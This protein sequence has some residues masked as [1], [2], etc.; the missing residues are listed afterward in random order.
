MMDAILA[1][2]GIAA[3]YAFGCFIRRE[4]MVNAPGGRRQFFI[5]V[6]AFVII[7][8]PMAQLLLAVGND[9]WAMGLVGAIVFEHG[10]FLPP[11][12]NAYLGN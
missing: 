4:V 1:G 12:I 10:Y 6:L 2:L 7:A 8:I 3:V 5:D 9:R 11:H